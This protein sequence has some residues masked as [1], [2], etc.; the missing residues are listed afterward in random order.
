MFVV[1][2]GRAFDFTV[3][4]FLIL[5]NLPVF[6]MLHAAFTNKRKEWWAQSQTKALSQTRL[7]LPVQLKLVCIYSCHINVLL[8]I[9]QPT[10]QSKMVSLA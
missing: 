9:R 7:S 1:A 2:R 6:C 10:I 3:D 5:E 8:D 4:A